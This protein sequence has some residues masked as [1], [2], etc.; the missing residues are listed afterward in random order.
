MTTDA[1]GTQQSGCVSVTT[2]TAS[3][4]RVCT[5][6]AKCTL[7]LLPLIALGWL[8]AAR[9]DNLEGSEALSQLPQLQLQQEFC[10]LVN[11][12]VLTRADAALTWLCAARDET[13]GVP[14][15]ASELWDC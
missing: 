15:G 10:T 4:A 11:P 12:N 5:L 14:D 3:A 13:S 9:A 2:D 1:G 6:L 7:K 8:F